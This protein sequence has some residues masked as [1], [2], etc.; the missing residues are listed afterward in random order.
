[1]NQPITSQFFIRFMIGLLLFATAGVLIWVFKSLAATVAIAV[2]IYLILDAP[3]KFIQHLG[4][5]RWQALIV[6]FLVVHIFIFGGILVLGTQIYGDVQVI[7]DEIPSLKNRV[8]TIIAESEEVF[9]AIELSS[10]LN[11]ERLQSLQEY[12]VSIIS[13]VF[14]L[15][16]TWVVNVF[17]I[18]PILTI[19]LLLSGHNLKEF[20]LSFVPNSYFEMSVTLIDKVIET[21]RE[22][23]FAKFLESFVI[24]IICVVGFL[25]FGLPGAIVLGILAGVLNL[26]PYFGPLISFIPPVIIAIINN[27]STLAFGAA[28]V[29]IFAQ[30][31]HYTPLTRGV[32]YYPSIYTP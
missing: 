30:I 2:I 24:A 29:I 1:M 9:P 20:F 16:S 13:S 21:I 14:K 23:I 6:T 22:Y 26:I 8:Q 11:A 5:P 32:A 17:L 10:L 19:I 4:I 27:D 15:L 7:T 12:L 31:I 3:T 18:I 28:G 25:L